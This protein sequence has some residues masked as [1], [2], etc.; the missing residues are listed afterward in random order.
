MESFNIK[1]KASVKYYEEYLNQVE[2]ENG[3]QIQLDF[4][5]INGEINNSYL[6]RV[7]KPDKN[8]MDDSVISDS[9]TCTNYEKINL[10]NYNCEYNFGKEQILK[11]ELLIKFSSN[12]KSYKSFPISTSIGEIVG[13]ENS[14]KIFDIQ[15]RNE[16]LEVRAQKLKNK[17]N[18]LTFHFHLKIIS[19]NSG[20]ISKDLQ[21]KFFKNEKC[22]LYFKIK[23]NNSI[24]YESESYTDDGKF[25]MA[26]VPLKFFDSDF[27]ILFF[28]YKNKMVGE[29][30]TN[31]NKIA[32][33]K[34]K[35]KLFLKLGLTKNESLCLYNLSSIRKEITFLDYINNGVRVALDIGI[36]FTGS[37]GHPDDEGTL[38]CRLPN[39][40]QRN[41]YERAILSCAT[42]MAN[43]DYDQK[44]PVY[45]FGALIKGQKEVSMCF[46]INFKK[47]PNIQYVDNIMKEYFA[48]LDK[49]VFSGPT[50]F[51]PI[52]NKIISEMKNED[53]IMNYHVLMILTDGKI[54]DY[55]DTVD[56]LVEGSFL[57]LSVIII[58]IGNNPNDE[59]QKEDFKFMEQLDGDDVPLI[60]RKGVK[61]QRDLV[62]FVPF[63]K[64][65]Y[66]EKKLTEE[67]LDEIPRQIIEYYT[68]N[69]LYPE[70]LSSSS[71][72]EGNNSSLEQSQSQISSSSVNNS[73][74][75][76]FTN[77]PNQNYI[78]NNEVNYSNQVAQH[79]Y[80]G[81]QNHGGNNNFSN[82]MVSNGDG[83]TNNQNPYYN[84]N[85]NPNSSSY[86]LNWN[87]IKK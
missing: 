77:L 71:P 57:P 65:E 83:F 40:E 80:S 14:T 7:Q 32:H 41:P 54:D 55:E 6:I 9:I 31:A 75:H 87:S 52:I 60:S 48:C 33:P 35:N 44:F 46:N 72:S 30:V 47:D 61:R 58:G 17:T 74:E 38:H 76:S 78:P 62:Q 37:N 79:T 1:S 22:K 27:S 66:D 49:I 18:F 73:S 26:Q 8:H 13:N 19:S 63:N 20:Q 84:Y 68:L 15:D 67:V 23:K 4:N 39:M 11:I 59:K 16:Q 29:V 43:Y 12:I 28:N 51:A 42:V 50:C 85:T 34:N 64:F 53:D 36:D 86:G 69:F 5:L 82:S 70:L 10:F 21:E 24:L 81:H 25:N 2:N 3:E 56:A 45:G